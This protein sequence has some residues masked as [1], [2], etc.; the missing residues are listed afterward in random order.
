MYNDDYKLI[1][2]TDTNGKEDAYAYDKHGNL[3]KHEDEY[4]I[5][6]YYYN[7]NDQLVEYIRKVK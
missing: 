5:K 4:Y 7:G 6:E 2:S 3:S 1:L